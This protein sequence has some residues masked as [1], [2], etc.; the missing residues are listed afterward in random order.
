MDVHLPELS[1]PPLETDFRDVRLSA[2]LLDA[3]RSTIRLAQQANLVFGRIP[4]AFHVSSP[5][6]GPRLTRQ[7]VRKSEVTSILCVLA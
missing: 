3:L 7:P 6:Y 4:L 1:L 5:F 2:E